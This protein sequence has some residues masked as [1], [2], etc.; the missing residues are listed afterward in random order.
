MGVILDRASAVLLHGASRKAAITQCREMIATGTNLAGVVGSDAYEEL[1]RDLGVS[2]FTSIAA[3]VAH[4]RIDAVVIYDGPRDARATIENAIALGIATIICATEGMPLHDVR[5]VCRAAQCA[6]VTL[7]GPHSNGVLVPQVTKAGYFTN[8]LCAPG[9]IGLVTN[10]GS[11][12]YDV[13][14]ELKSLGLGLSTVVSVGQDDQKGIS[15]AEVLRLFQNDPETAII[16]LIGKISGHEEED[17]AHTIRVFVTK[18]V[19][20]FISKADSGGTNDG[21]LKEHLD[22]H[23]GDLLSKIATLRHAGAFVVDRFRDI[24]PETV[25]IAGTKCGQQK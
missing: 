3:A 6:G 4:S 23:C 21:L 24:V 16:L 18:P 25:R 15:Y 19:V 1:T 9:R 5:A 10:G 8:D 17:A 20:A 22:G 14:S 11:V 2:V 12:V 7:I 13:M